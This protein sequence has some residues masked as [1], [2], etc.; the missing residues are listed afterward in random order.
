VEIDES[1]R[2]EPD[3]RA[4][5]RYRELQAFHDAFSEA[6]RPVFERHASFRG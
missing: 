4:H 6:M 2:I 3:A 1:T 5:E